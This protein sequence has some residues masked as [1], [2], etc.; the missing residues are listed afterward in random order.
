MKEN[1]KGIDPEFE[2]E[3]DDVV[4]MMQLLREMGLTDVQRHEAKGIILGMRMAN[5]AEA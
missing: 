1:T 5:A 3:K 4:S 2:K